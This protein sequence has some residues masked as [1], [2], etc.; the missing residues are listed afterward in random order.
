M[1]RKWIDLFLGSTVALCISLVFALPAQAKDCGGNIECACGDNVVASRTL[2][3]DAVLKGIC[4]G[5]A[6]F[7]NTPGVTVIFKKKP[8]A[9]SPNRYEQWSPGDGIHIT[10]DNVTIQKGRIE[11]FQRGIFGTTNGSRFL[12]VNAED[13]AVNGIN[14][15]GNGNTFDEAAG[16]QSLGPNAGDGIR[17]T[18]NNNVLTSNYSE[19]ALAGAVAIR[20][21]GSGNFLEDNFVEGNQGGG[22]LVTGGGNIDGGGNKAKKTIGTPK[23]EID[24]FV[25]QP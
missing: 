11:G 22:I 20:V 17:I 6:L 3:S 9:G 1:A 5:T 24:G 19:K 25:C 2:E 21:I 23:C 8:L 16:S 7:M 18:G 13:N 15:T 4:P 10:A 14:I 12:N